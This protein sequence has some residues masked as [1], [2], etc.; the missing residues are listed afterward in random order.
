MYK[1]LMII[2]EAWGTNKHSTELYRQYHKFEKTSI[3][4]G[5]LEKIPNGELVTLE[6]DMGWEDVGIS[7]ETFYRGLVTS[8]MKDDTVEEGG[9]DT[10]YLESERNLVIVPKG[11]MIGLVG[12]SD[13]MIIDTPNGLL[14]G[15]ISD[16]Q[17]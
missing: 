2:S 12:V 10:A 16:S 4:Y 15:K 14:V 6:A 3:D 9:V 13:M 8:S 1:G 11:K 7:W 17:K 5:L